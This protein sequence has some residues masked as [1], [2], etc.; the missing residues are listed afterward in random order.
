MITLI[1]AQGLNGELGL[2]NGLPWKEPADIE[3]FKKRILKRPLIVGRTTYENLPKSVFRGQDV[4]V[5]T[6]D[7]NYV[8]SKSPK[9]ERFRSLVDVV[10]NH[11]GEEIMVI[12]GKTV[13]EEFQL[14]ADRMVVTYINKA[15]I[16]ADVFISEL[17]HNMV[18]K[19]I[20]AISETAT[21]VVYERY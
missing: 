10:D 20:K 3:H 19:G 14:V 18:M 11:P 17:T 21:V 5:M 13:Y 6:T 8:P 1:W 15:N 12:G 2:N 4:Y 16:E 7:D 9:H